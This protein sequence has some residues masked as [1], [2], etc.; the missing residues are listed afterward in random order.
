MTVAVGIVLVKDASWTMVAWLA[1]ATAPCR[2]AMP[3]RATGAGTGTR[4]RR[5]YCRSTV[6]G[7][8]TWCM[9]VTRL[10]PSAQRARPSA[11][12]RPISDGAPPYR[13]SSN[14]RCVTGARDSSAAAIAAGSAPGPSANRRRTSMPPSWNVA[15]SPASSGAITATCMPARLSALAR[16]AVYEATPLWPAVQLA[17]RR[18]GGDE[19]DVRT[20]AHQDARTSTS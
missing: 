17:L 3:A 8:T 11:G 15:G 5:V 1:R 6:A 14:C 9:V 10:E 12:P 13:N 18:I 19:R 7:S 20:P 2:A 4:W 16:F